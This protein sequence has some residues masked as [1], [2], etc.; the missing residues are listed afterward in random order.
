[1]THEEFAIRR[2]IGG[3]QGNACEE[4]GDVEELH[5][6]WF[7]NAK[8]SLDAVIVFGRGLKQTF[9]PV[10]FDVLYINLLTVGPGAMTEKWQGS[11]KKY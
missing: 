9:D 6:G 2:G 4:E 1:M 10:G 11:G 8:L 3:G 5:F 7:C